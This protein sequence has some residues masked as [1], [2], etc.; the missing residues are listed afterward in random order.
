MVKAPVGYVVPPFPGLYWPSSDSF[1]HSYLYH[2]SDVWMFT[3]VWGIILTTGVYTLAA[4]CI[5]VTHWRNKTRRRRVVAIALVY[6]LWGGANGFF[7]GSI[8]GVV[9]AALYNAT[10]FRLTP[11]IPFVWGVI[12]M[13]YA[14]VSSYKFYISII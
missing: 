8:I 11:W 10:Q 14:V 6:V 2:I 1:S 4:L 12:I 13:I 9:I 5:L 3:A 7:A